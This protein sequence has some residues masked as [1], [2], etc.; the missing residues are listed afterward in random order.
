[1]TALVVQT[2]TSALKPMG[3]TTLGRWEPEAVGTRKWSGKLE[4]VLTFMISMLKPTA[5]SGSHISDHSPQ[6]LLL[7]SSQVSEL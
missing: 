7:I 2:L 5:A 3:Q 6:S 4:K 1:M